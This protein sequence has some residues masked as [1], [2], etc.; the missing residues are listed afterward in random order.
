LPAGPEV[1]AETPAIVRVLYP[2]Q[3]NPDPKPGV[4]DLW[5]SITLA[6]LPDFIYYFCMELLVFCVRFV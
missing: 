1:R 2:E 4:P 5:G 3:G 6:S